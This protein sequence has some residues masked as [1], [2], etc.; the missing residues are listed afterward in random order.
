MAKYSMR[1]EI[2]SEVRFTLT[3]TMSLEDW[4]KL[5]RAFGNV[6]YQHGVESLKQAISDMVRQAEA[7]FE[8]EPPADAV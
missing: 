8:Y 2:P 1:A 7:R 3:M 4:V 6:Q 5:G